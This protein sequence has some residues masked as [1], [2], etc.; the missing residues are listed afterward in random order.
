[1]VV[2][3]AAVVVEGV[4]SPSPSSSSES[5]KN[6]SN[7]SVAPLTSTEKMLQSWGW[8][9]ASSGSPSVCSASFLPSSERQDTR[10]LR[11]CDAE[12][13]VDNWGGDDRVDVVDDLPATC[14]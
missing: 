2:V 4:S 3:E 9:Q 5:S 14:I 6:P 10:C 8:R 11:N 1:M 13:M 7:L 12:S